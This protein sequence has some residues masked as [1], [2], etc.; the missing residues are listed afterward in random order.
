MIS[1]W[2]MFTSA[3][4]RIARDLS[5][6]TDSSAYG[7]I[8]ALQKFFFNW[9]IFYLTSLT[10][11]NNRTCYLDRG[12]IIQ[13]YTSMKYY[14]INPKSNTPTISSSLY[15]A[16]FSR[17]SHTK[18]V[19]LS[20]SQMYFLLQYFESKLYPASHCHRKSFDCTYNIDLYPL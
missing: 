12:I 19:V 14:I 6:I 11:D 5:S 17:N 1:K 2:R 8:M 18:F 15:K 10:L 13:Y 4:N 7:S 3:A 16:L 9:F 20:C